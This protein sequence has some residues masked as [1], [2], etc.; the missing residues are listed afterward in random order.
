MCLIDVWELR[1]TFGKYEKPD[2]TGK[3][4]IKYIIHT[5]TELLNRQKKT[6]KTVSIKS[7]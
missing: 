6:K 3:S 1:T 5:H 2:V 4:Y 7:Q